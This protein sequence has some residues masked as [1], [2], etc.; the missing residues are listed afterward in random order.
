[1]KFTL[2]KGFLQKQNLNEVVKIMSDPLHVS[3]YIAHLMMFSILLLLFTFHN[4]IDK[5]KK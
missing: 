2:K 5:F 4:Q 3:R 1:M